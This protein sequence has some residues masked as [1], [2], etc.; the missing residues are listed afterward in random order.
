MKYF[1]ERLK[2]VVSC[3]LQPNAAGKVWINLTQ[4]EWS[5]HYNTTL[6]SGNTVDLR[7]FKGDYEITVK[8][9]GN[10]VKVV[11]FKATGDHTALDVHVN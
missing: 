11:P 3:P 5:T 9:S 6:S 4:N 2:N 7:G 8:V 10:T 1:T